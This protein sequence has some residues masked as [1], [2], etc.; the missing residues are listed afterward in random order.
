M[1]RA[2]PLVLLLV[3][4]AV[5]AP[6]PDAE[7]D[8]LAIAQAFGTW[9]DPTREN[10]FR[11]DGLQLRLR[12]PGAPWRVGFDTP[13]P[14]VVP[15]FARRVTGDFSAEVR[16]ACPALADGVLAN[17]RALAGGLLAS[18]ATGARIAVCRCERS[19]AN[20]RSEFTASWFVPPGLGGA[21]GAS[22]NENRGRGWVKLVRTGPTVR[23]GI[24]R[25]AGEWQMFEPVTVGWTGPVEVG[26]FA[27]NTT[28]VRAEVT[29]DNYSLTQPKK[30]PEASP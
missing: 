5:A 7:R 20:C 24:R 30:G 2:I 28:G 8:R 26:V 17:E 4:P 19:S 21:M 18:D 11:V 22:A 29:F 27:E 25:E 6:I 23:Y 12:L 14:W 16:V 15:H 13:A 9:T 10:S 3:V 1:T